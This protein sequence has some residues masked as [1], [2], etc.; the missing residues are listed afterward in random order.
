MKAN[1]RPEYEHLRSW[2]EHLPYTFFEQGQ[3]IYN[4]RN[5][6]RVIEA[7]DGMVYNVKRYC[8]PPWYNRIIYTIFRPSKA[9]RAFENAIRIL[10]CGIATPNP[11]GYLLC[12]GTWL[13]ES[14]LITEHVPHA[15][16]LY[17]WGDGLTQGRE[18][19]M[20]SFGRFTARMHLKQIY[21]L[22]YS[23]G[24]ILYDWINGQLEFVVVDINRMFFKPISVKLGCAN[25]GR[26]W[27]EEQVY[28]LIAK[29]YADERE[30]DAD[31]C[32]RLMWKAHVHFWRYR[33]KPI[34]YQ[35]KVK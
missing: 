33:E 26:L 32:F 30:S 8:C 22:D 11:I 20:I 23:P 17:E 4:A 29:G 24:N 13:A 2:I 31:L 1:I 16:R 6:I 15:H 27:G 18:E 25:M 35:S 34:E 9:K 28:Q 14:F 12:G 21:H 10:N 5:Q 7:P 19:L 3:I